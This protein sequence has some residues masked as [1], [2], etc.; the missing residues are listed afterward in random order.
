MGKTFKFWILPLLISLGFFIVVRPIFAQLVQGQA[1][2]ADY[3]TS[4]NVEVGS[5]EE[6][7]YRQIYYVWDGNKVF[8][9]NTSY[10]NSDPV[11]EKE[12]IVWMAQIDDGWR[13]FLYNILSGSTVQLTQ[14]GMNVN[15]KISAGSIVWET[16]D[17]K[18]VWQIDLFDGKSVNQI[19]SGDMSVNV[20]IEG[21]FIAYGRKDI[22]EW[23]GSL[24]SIKMREEIDI[25][26]GEKANSP[27]LKDGKILLNNGS[28]EFPLKVEDIFTLDLAPLT[29][30]QIETVTSEQI[31]DELQITN[32]T[33]SAVIEESTPSSAV[34]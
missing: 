15:P 2:L 14:T 11:T 29:N 32:A 34:Q 1:S 27:K 18:G 5:E 10:T 21:N 25:T 8:I 28:I 4:N 22:T 20:D 30:N 19:T 33:N 6:G 12:N 17:D 23:R 16:Q 24:Y 31:M 26:T 9:T 3:L 13:I 7:G